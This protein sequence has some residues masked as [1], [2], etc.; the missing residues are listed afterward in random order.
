MTTTVLSPR[1]SDALV[2]A[3]FVHRNQQRKGSGVPY[4]GHL[5]GVTDIVLGAGGNE[6]EAIAALLHDAAEDQGGRHELE[7]IRLRFGD[8]VAHIVEAL[9]DDLPE[10]AGARKQP[11]H[12]RKEAYHHHLQANPDASVWLVSAADK[13]N[14]ARA[15]LT[16]LRADGPVVWERFSAVPSEQVWNYG[17]LLEIYR[18]SDDPRLRPIVDE[19][20]RVYADLKEEA[21]KL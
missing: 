11:W 21:A 17:Q 3:A 20:A 16:D 8:R 10:K 15:T 4:I 12:P 9:S 7:Q 1:F 14:N 5:L 13:L 18:T 2:Y 6:D 19:L